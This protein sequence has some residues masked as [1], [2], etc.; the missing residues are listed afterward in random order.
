MSSPE[1]SPSANIKEPEQ[2]AAID[3][4]SNSFHMVIGKVSQ[5][6]VRI[7]GKLAEKVQLAAGLNENQELTLEAQ[8][9]ALDCLGRFSE[10]LEGFPRGSVRVVGTSAL[11]QARN[12]AVF[13]EKAGKLLGHPIE[14]IAGREE[15]RLIYLGA[16][17]ILADDKGQRLVMDI[18]G[19]STEFVIGNRFEAIELESLHMGCVGYGQRFFSDGEINK[20]NFTKAVVAAR[21]EVWAIDTQFRSTGW[22]DVVGASGSI[23]AIEQVAVQSGL[24]DEGITFDALKVIKEKIIKAKHYS[25]FDLLGLKEERASIFAPGVAILYGIFKQLKIKE[26][27]YSDGALREGLLY[28]Q[29]GRIRHED[30]RDRTT[31]AMMSRHHVDDRQAD[32]VKETALKLCTMVAPDWGLDLALYRDVL[33]RAALLHEVGLS[34]SHSQFHKHGA[35]LVKYSDLAGFSRQEQLAISMLVRGH[36]RKIPVRDLDDL[37]DNWYEVVSRMMIL[38]RIAVLFHHSRTDNPLPK[39]DLKV[40]NQSMKLSFAKGYLDEHPLTN[41]DFLQ[42]KEYLRA[43]GITLS[44]E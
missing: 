18:G 5:G 9:R 40:D 16:S 10:R 6:E 19:G 43:V 11:R 39:I 30:V 29:L 35:Y 34:I 41:H 23:K 25:N 37:P 33:R 22:E 42:E 17:H 1:Q 14:I 15:A 28:D 13:L 3:M 2:I 44:V 31:L 26:M 8:G 38:L 36:R 32:R 7:I 21:R 20:R 24:C 12:A 4:G 27:R